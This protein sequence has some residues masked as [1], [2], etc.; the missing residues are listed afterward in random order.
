M[1]VAAGM[2]RLAFLLADATR[3]VNSATSAAGHRETNPLL[4]VSEFFGVG[5]IG[6]DIGLAGCAGDVSPDPE[7]VIIDDPSWGGANRTG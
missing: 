7:R 5:H 6:G 1:T 4:G 3:V 2:Q